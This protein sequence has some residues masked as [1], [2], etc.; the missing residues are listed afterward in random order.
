MKPA[1]S[2]PH[3]TIP[4]SV[5]W[6][7][8]L[9]AILWG[10]SWPFMKLS[11]SGMEPLRYRTFSM[12][13]AM[14]G[15]FLIARLTRASLRLPAGA[16]PR[17]VLIAFFNMAAWSMLMIF[18]LQLLPAGRASILAYTFP[19]WTVP[20]SAWLM[21]EPITARK[22][23]GLVLGLGGMGLLI[24]DELLVMGRSP[25][26]ALLLIGS[27][28]VW[29]IGTVAMKR[30]PVQ[31]PLVSFTAWQTLVALVPILALALW[32]ENGPMH[33]FGLPLP[34]MLAVLYGALIASIFAQWM[35]YRIVQLT[36]A[37]V[38]SISITVVPV[39]GVFFSMLILDEAPHA[40][41]YAALALVVGSLGF[42]LV[43]PRARRG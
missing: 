12:F 31:M 13:G 1:S 11:L 20:L 42:I 23:C 4:V 32:L 34:V 6:M 17:L 29:A 18:G 41:D 3:A 30:W 28:V 9:V 40:S 21:R 25:L 27:A 19:L 36:S 7:L 14:S 8:A 22:I 2:S 39:M 16:L 10:L 33:P 5:Y 37:A 26:G 24:G 38:S 35:W 43:P 15:L